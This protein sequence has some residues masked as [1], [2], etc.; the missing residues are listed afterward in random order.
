MKAFEVN[1]RRKNSQEVVKTVIVEHF[2]DLG[3][4]LRGCIIARIEGF[5]FDKRKHS[6][7]FKE[8]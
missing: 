8:I 6:A 4:I 1:F 3:I 7:S 5:R 2:N